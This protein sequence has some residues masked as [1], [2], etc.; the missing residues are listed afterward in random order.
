MSGRR[1]ETALGVARARFVEGLPRRTRELKGAI[2]LLTAS[3]EDT[4]A[5]EELRRR[6]HALFASAQV[7]R[8]ELLADGLKSCIALLDAAR[9]GHRA[10][11]DAE[12]EELAR[13]ALALPDLALSSSAR[14]ASLAPPTMIKTIPARDP[15]EDEGAEEPAS[16]GSLVPSIADLKAPK[17]PRKELESVEEA[18][19]RLATVSTPSR[20]A[21]PRADDPFDEAV[22]TAG[23]LSAA[24]ALEAAL[25]LSPS[26]AA[27]PVP[28]P[29]PRVTLPKPPIVP[30]VPRSKPIT[31]PPAPNPRGAGLGLPTVVS[32]LVVDSAV[33]Q[34]H[35]REALPAERFEV[36][37]VTDPEEALRLARTTAPDVVLASKAVVELR[38]I[39]FV[40]RLRS[41][42]LNGGVPL[43]LLWPAGQPVDATVVGGT[44]ADDVVASP[45]D[46]DGL[47]T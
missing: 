36:I 10:L 8:I 35:M 33:G 2:A 22:T 38:D 23:A 17:P 20:A 11:T 7:F 39:D 37:S 46:P 6:L 41:D 14:G 21:M 47:A 27:L 45:V 43:L 26:T 24:D 18:V 34:A 40:T 12:L 15:D 29:Q 9:E 32:V 3:P 5:R 1:E 44:G 4:R 31:T 30:S 16:G 25:D 13:I 42:P 28:A 19:L